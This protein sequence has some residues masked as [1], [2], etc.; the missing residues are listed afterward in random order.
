MLRLRI[1]VSETWGGKD[2]SDIKTVDVDLPEVEAY[3]RANGHYPDGVIIDRHVAGVELVP[4][5]DWRN[6]TGP[7][8]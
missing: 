1:D 4:P 5:V 3:L 2:F 7:R 6:P 8:D